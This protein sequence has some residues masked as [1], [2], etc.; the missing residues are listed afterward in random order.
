MNF[1]AQ[2]FIFSVCL[3]SLI[4]IGGLYPITL[5]GDAGYYWRVCIVLG[6]KPSNFLHP[7]GYTAWFCKEKK[8]LLANVTYKNTQHKN[9]RQEHICYQKTK[10]IQCFNHNIRCLPQL[11]A[12]Q[13]R[14]SLCIWSSPFCYRSY[15]CLFKLHVIKL[16]QR[17]LNTAV[18]TYRRMQNSGWE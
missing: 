5:N 16:N 6:R 17:L 15:I 7:L 13:T 4:C 8:N 14:A 2:V 12:Y 9:F 10:A 1:T 11:Y 3:R 18:A